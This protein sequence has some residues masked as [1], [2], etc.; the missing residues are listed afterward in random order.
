M[1][2][3]LN[4]NK[5][6]ILDAYKK[7]TENQDGYDFAIFGY[8]GKSNDL[9]LEIIG[10]GGLETI[11]EEINEGKIQY[12]FVRIIDPSTQLI[13]FLLINFQ[14][15]S[16]L[17]LVRKGTCSN[18]IRDI[19]NLLK[20]NVTITATNLD[21]LDEEAIMKK[22]SKTSSSYNFKERVVQDERIVVGTNYSRVVPK[23]EIDPR[24]RDE[25][26]KK[27]EMVEKER[28]ALEMETKRLG[29]MKIEEERLKRE[30]SEHLKR[31]QFNKSVESKAP[32]VSK[33]PEIPV[34]TADR[35]DREMPRTNQADQARMG[36]R[37][38]AAE[39]IGNTVNTAKA[40]FQQQASNQATTIVTPPVKP[41]RK[42]IQKPEAP[43]EVI[44]EPIPQPIQEPVA[45]VEATPAPIPIQEPTP[46]PIEVKPVEKTMELPQE[47]KHESISQNEDQYSTIKRSPYTKTPT[48]PDND[49]ISKTTDNMQQQLTDNI[50]VEQQQQ[51]IVVEQQQPMVETQ[52]QQQEAD[53]S[54]T[55]QQFLKAVA[56]YDY[57]AMDE[58]EI[59]FDPG[60]LITHIDQIDEGWWQGLSERF[61]NYGLFPANYVELIN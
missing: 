61:G 34:K 17:D 2:V 51:P 46:V 47:F 30:Q 49:I 1:S 56:I 35:E 32:P 60:D 3:N 16:V 21:D 59:S 50:I 42:T 7:V 22:I 52:L 37:K 57:Q 4:K 44:P 48:T 24:Q 11:S 20:N 13:K 55:E 28:V 23:K 5:D 6:A 15:E 31:E 41:I 25:F 36:R 43:V 38:E 12:A 8:E 14:G 27:E 29:N 54:P 45:I 19:S 10:S 9:R 18:H 39:L 58:T 33:T 26:W 40:L 53:V